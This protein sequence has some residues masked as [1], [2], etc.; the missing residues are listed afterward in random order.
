MKKWQNADGTFKEMNTAEMENLTNEEH[1]EYLTAKNSNLDTIIK[2][3][4]EEGKVANAGQIAEL[5]NEMLENVKKSFDILK[6]HGEALSN[7][8]VAN[9]KTG[10]KVSFKDAVEISMK[11]NDEKI[12]AFKSGKIDSTGDIELK[13]NVTDASVIGSTA[14]YRLDGIGKQPVRRVFL[15][16][17]FSQGR[18]SANSGGTIT[19]WDQDTVTRNAD[20]VAEAG[21]IPESAITWQE[22]SIK[23]E[24][25]ADSIPVTEEALEDYDFIESEVRN[26]LLENVLLKLDQQ[27]LAGTGTTPQLAGIDSVAQT[28]VA[29]AYAV[30]VPTPT[31]FDVIKIGKTQI[32]NS[33]QNNAFMANVVLMNETDLTSM[34]LEK[35]ADGQYLLPN[36]MSS[37]GLTIDGMRVITSPLVTANS[38]YIMDSTKATVYSHRDLAVNFANQ[39]SDDFLKDIIRMKASLRKSF[40]IRNVNANAFLKVTSISAAKTAITKP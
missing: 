9:V 40:V 8:K 2:A 5:K 33:G 37:E 13:T 14:S 34:Q 15:E 32:S 36:Y 30:L 1:D 27:I 7:M 24:K 20:N 31:I 38:M 39:H 17:L 25:I 4:V 21:V 23:V 16:S 35:D 19:Y 6:E 3:L 29:G 10:E 12:K 26:F 18:V 28:W 22:Y 11:A